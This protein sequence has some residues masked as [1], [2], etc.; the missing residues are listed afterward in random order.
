[1]IIMVMC[2]LQTFLIT[3]VI[4][5]NTYLTFTYIICIIFL[6]YKINK[7]VGE[8]GCLTNIF[9][10][11]TIFSIFTL[12]LGSL[13]IGKNLCF[14]FLK[15]QIYK[16]KVIKIE[17]YTESERVNNRTKTVKYY[18]P[19]FQFIDN[20]NNVLK[21]KSS[22]S[23]TDSPTIGSEK[24]VIYIK[25]NNSVLEN[26]VISILFLLFAFLSTTIFGFISFSIIQYALGKDMTINKKIFFSSMF[27]GL[28]CGI[29]IFEILLI[30]SFFNTLKNGLLNYLL[31]LFIVI[32]SPIIYLL[33]RNNFTTRS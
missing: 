17:S 33:W 11:V 2:F 9:A 29:I 23:G 5:T 27:Y 7:R 8:R 6:S 28:K 32:L 14:H 13:Y 1:M 24:E 4:S 21:L 31:L 15:G 30:Y 16:A 26:G 19:I 18:T 3:N 20:E 10:F 12:L 22:T 25:G